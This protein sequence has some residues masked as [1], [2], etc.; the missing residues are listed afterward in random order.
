MTRD[1]GWLNIHKPIGISS[2]GVVKKIKFFFNLDKIGHGG[3]LDPLAEGV[4]P[5][6]IGK[7]T[8]LIPFINSDIIYRLE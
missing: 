5:I 6:A 3:T 4:L 7:A 2:F 8:K 1:Q